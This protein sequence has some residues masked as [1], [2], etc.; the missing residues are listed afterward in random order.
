MLVGLISLTHLPLS[1]AGTDSRIEDPTDPEFGAL[2]FKD[3][4]AVL[5]SCTPSALHK[6]L[7]TVNINVLQHLS[8][9]KVVQLSHFC[10]QRGVAK[11]SREAFEIIKVHIGDGSEE[12]P[13]DLL[14]YRGCID[15]Q[16]LIHCQSF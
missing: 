5:R 15:T 13:E 9:I 6:D 7:R 14:S 4:T 16:K 2:Q 8:N 3:L 10:C 11:E 12:L 1:Q